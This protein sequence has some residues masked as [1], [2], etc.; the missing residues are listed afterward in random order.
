MRSFLH[1]FDY[2]L[3]IFIQQWPQLHGFMLAMTHFGHP[4]VAISIAALIGT[5]GA[6]L[7]NLRLILSAGVVVVMIVISSV[8]KELLHRARP[9][10]DYVAHM[11]S[12][13][14]SFP[15][16]HAVG[17]TMAYGLIAYLAWHHLPQPWSSVVM[18]ICFL[19]IF[20]VGVSRVYLGA[21]YPSD[22]I[23]GWL[24]GMVGLA[25]IIFVIKP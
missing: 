20:I 24:L 10:T 11:T 22:V 7:S 6:L 13:S 23:G 8:L 3:T 17:A 25:I 12:F 16:G 4:V 9:L 2:N 5:T 19:L 1:N 15:S 18:T 21:H 14:L